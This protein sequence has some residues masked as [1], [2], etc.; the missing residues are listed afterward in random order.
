MY[1]RGQIYDVIIPVALS[2]AAY[3]VFSNSSNTPGAAVNTVGITTCLLPYS[4]SDSSKG[5]TGLVKNIL[6]A[7]KKKFYYLG[8]KY[9]IIDKIKN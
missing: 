1:I 6:I 2:L 9:E 4:F 7:L 8:G 5:F 3:S